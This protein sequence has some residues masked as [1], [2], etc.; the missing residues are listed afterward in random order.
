M[1]GEASWEDEDHSRKREGNCGTVIWLAENERRGTPP[2]VG[3]RMNDE[4]NE[5]G[6]NGIR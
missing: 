6:R 4:L 3:T 2:L 1:K 5:V